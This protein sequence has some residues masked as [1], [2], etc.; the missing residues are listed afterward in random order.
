M[1][2]VSHPF[3]STNKTIASTI[4]TFV[5]KVMSLLFNTL[6]RFIIAFLPRSKCLLISMAVAAFHSDFGAQENKVSHC[7]HFS[8]HL[9]AMKW[10]DQIPWSSFFECWALSQLFHSPLSLS[11]RGSL[12]PLCLLPLGWYHLHIWGYWFSSQQSWFQLRLHSALQES[13]VT[14]YSLEVRLSQFWTSLLFH[15]WI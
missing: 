3:M 10:W 9:F 1:V 8:P 12:V 4:W 15:V 13:K 7:F 6:S 2:Q 11:S 14:I 5:D